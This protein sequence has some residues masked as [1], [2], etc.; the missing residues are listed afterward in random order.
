MLVC[1]QYLHVE[2]FTVGLAPG[3]VQGCD[4]LY[5]H[6]DTC[7]VEHLN[8]QIF[9]YGEGK[10]PSCQI[11]FP[12]ILLQWC[13]RYRVSAHTFTTALTCTPSQAPNSPRM[14]C[15]CL[16]PDFSGSLFFHSPFDSTWAS[17]CIFCLNQQLL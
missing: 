4:A 5:Q 6:S 10:A 13:I 15:L 9:C 16:I 3:I 17:Q 11:P 7:V 2:G 8:W 1:F 14:I 12:C